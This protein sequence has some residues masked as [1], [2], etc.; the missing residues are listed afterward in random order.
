MMK[1]LSMKDILSR[2]C[3]FQM[4]GVTP[5]PAAEGAGGGA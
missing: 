5:S 2:L 4:I 3:R 1:I